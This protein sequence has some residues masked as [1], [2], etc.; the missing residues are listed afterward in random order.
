MYT[1]LHNKRTD[2]ARYKAG[3]TTAKTTKTTSA[4]R[5]R[6]RWE[7]G[8]TILRFFFFLNVNWIEKW[9]E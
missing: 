6:T 9:C 5:K 8:G 3:K 7:K 2:S 1:G 4:K